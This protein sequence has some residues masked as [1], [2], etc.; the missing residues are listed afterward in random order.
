M[1]AQ[2]DKC[3]LQKSFVRAASTRERCSFGPSAEPLYS[4]CRTAVESIDKSALEIAHFRTAAAQEIGFSK[5]LCR[6]REVER[7]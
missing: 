5:R 4:I 1:E 7:V 2:T 3:E 6:A